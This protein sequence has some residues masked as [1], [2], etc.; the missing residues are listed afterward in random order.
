VTARVE[1]VA[2][3]ELGGDV[4]DG[5]VGFEVCRLADDLPVRGALA[6]DLDLAEDIFISLDFYF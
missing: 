2:G 4:L 6:I 5:A 1:F 3:Q